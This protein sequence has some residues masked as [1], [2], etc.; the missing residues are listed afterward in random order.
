M[1]MIVTK[2]LYVDILIFMI[3]IQSTNIKPLNNKKTQIFFVSFF[4]L[5]LFEILY[6]NLLFY[7]CCCCYYDYCY[8]YDDDDYDDDYYYYYIFH[9][10]FSF[11]AGFP[12]PSLPGLR[13]PGM[14]GPDG[15][16]LGLMGAAPP[17]PPP[18]MLPVMPPG[19]PPGFPPLN[20]MGRP[21]MMVRI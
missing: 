16:G 3:R 7:C 21:P 12:P 2:Y 4:I 1:I 19:M 6:F 17:L 11:V 5:F 13:P 8:C 20:I 14:L 9:S 18:N 10:K 15:N